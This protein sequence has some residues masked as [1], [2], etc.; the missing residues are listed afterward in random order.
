[1]SSANQAASELRAVFSR[2]RRRL[3]E[4]YSADG[5]TPSQT[6]VLIRLAKDGPATLS[7][8][9]A[10]ERVRPQSMATTLSAM[11][12]RGLLTRTAD[13][14]DGRRIQIALSEPGQELFA[15]RRRAS[16]EWLARALQER[17]TEEE[18][19]T[20]LAALAVLDRLVGV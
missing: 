19:Q 5:I 4:S 18:R 3:R 12:G 1:M 13:P 14:T 20:V 11:D 8:L 7:E 15:D 9:A 17:C 6:A 16:E 2:L 10:A